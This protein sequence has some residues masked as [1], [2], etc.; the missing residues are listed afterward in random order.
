MYYGSSNSKAL[1]PLVVHLNLYVLDLV[2]ESEIV[3]P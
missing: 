2:V 3:K 1:H